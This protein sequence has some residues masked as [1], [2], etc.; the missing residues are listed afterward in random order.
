METMMYKKLGLLL[1]ILSFV[2]YGFIFLLP[3]LNAQAST[4]VWITTIL[5]FAG[6]ASFWLGGIIL[7][8]EFVKKYR[9]FFNPKKW[10]KKQPQS[11]E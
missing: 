3:F 4:K 6:E 5:V 8:R 10:F 1:V 11:G 7:G 9:Q 2:L